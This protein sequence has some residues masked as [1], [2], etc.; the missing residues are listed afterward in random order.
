MT[1]LSILIVNWNTGRVLL[2]CLGSI[3]DNPPDLPF[4][5]ILVDNASTDESA[6]TA[7]TLY[8]QVQ[9]IHSPINLG[10]AAANNLAFD[11]A[12]GEFLLLLNP[13][14]IV[15]PEA[16]QV[17]LGYLAENPKA[18]AAGARLLNPDGS[19]QPSCSPEP[20][21][22]RE[23]MRLFHIKGV[24]PD[25]YHEMQDWDTAAPRRVD[26]LLGA[27]LMV[28]RAAQ[29]QIG[30]MDAAFFMY[31]EEVDYCRRLRQADWEIYWVPQAR[32]VHLGAQSTRQAASKMFLQLYLAKV[33]YF[34]KHHGRFSAQLY[35]LILFGAGVARLAASPLIEASPQSADQR[36]LVDNYQK[37]LKALP[38]M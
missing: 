10:F 35:K 6:H 22:S 34:R 15:Q 24:R 8:P 38:G 26:T 13:D 7:E 14:T 20:S 3:F 9:A 18:G 2:D 12:R 1:V 25:G 29:L 11:C 4:E 33:Q 17:L 16:L 32:V 5:V 19:L 28:R 36:T 21:L 30:S 23:F 37:L 31:S 27:C